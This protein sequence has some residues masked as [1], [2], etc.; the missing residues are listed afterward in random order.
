LENNGYVRANLAGFATTDLGGSTT[1]G[2]PDY[3][4]TVPQLT[5]G[6][7]TYLQY[8]AE[9]TG[10]CVLVF[11]VSTGNEN[12]VIA[13]V[14][15]SQ[16]NKRIRGLVTPTGDDFLPWLQC[17][18]FGWGDINRNGRPDI[19]VTLIWAN[20]YTGSELHIFEIVDDTTVTDLTKDLPGIMSPWDFDPSRTDQAVVDVAWAGHDCI[21]PPIYIFWIYDW[22]DGK[23]VDI[24]PELDFSNYL[25]SLKSD[26]TQN[27]GN[28]FN[29][30]SSIGPLTQL[31]LIYDRTGQR[32]KGWQ[33]YQDL[34]DLS[35]WPGTSIEDVKWLQSDIDHFT[36]EYKAGK[37]FTPNA[38]CN[39]PP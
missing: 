39:E 38:Y 19:P 30:F 4:R 9:K 36:Q 37:P 21:Y 35:H 34:T 17:S 5:H 22:R 18:P 25:A 28:P 15:V 11:V 13:T 33:E 6:K 12:T 27:Y 1:F 7:Y 10:N 29:A 3:K 8:V 32:D 20:Q 16:L 14:D 26:I 24:T 31:L 2:G 23:Y